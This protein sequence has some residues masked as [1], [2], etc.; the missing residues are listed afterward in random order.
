MSRGTQPTHYPQDKKK[1]AT[2]H[3]AEPT[4]TSPTRDLPPKDPEET[5]VQNPH[6]SDE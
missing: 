4:T 6:Q 5:A 2:I 3:K 1:Q